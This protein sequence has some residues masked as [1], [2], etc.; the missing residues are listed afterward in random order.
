MG[1]AALRRAK[2][3][4]GVF[5]SKG[6]QRTTDALLFARGNGLEHLRIAPAADHAGQPIHVETFGPADSRRRANAAQVVRAPRITRASP[7]KMQAPMKP[8]IR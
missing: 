4:H 1:A 3:E 6:I 7:I 5:A 8:A 2:V